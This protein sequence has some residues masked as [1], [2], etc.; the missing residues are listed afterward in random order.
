MQ[1]DDAIRL[2]HMLNAAKEARSFVKDGDWWVAWTDDVPGAMTQGSTVEEA[3]EN[4]ID[5]INEIRKPV[6]P[7]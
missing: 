5:A 7:T 3:R 6:E 4:L 2:R 1:K